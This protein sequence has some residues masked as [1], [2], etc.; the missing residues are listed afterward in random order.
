M[1]SGGIV[2]RVG[3]PENPAIAESV[4]LREV[5]RE[6]RLLT[7]A[8]PATVVSWRL[9]TLEMRAIARRVPRNQDSK[10]PI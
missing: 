4:A 8:R 5:P 7:Q 9:P 10:G 2:E 1:E 3:F 6:V